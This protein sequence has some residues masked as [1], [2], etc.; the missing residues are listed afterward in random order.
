MK[1]YKNLYDQVCDFQN[2]LESYK[3]ARKCK[4]NSDYVIHFE[5]ELEKNLFEIKEKL[6]N[7]IY[8]FGQYKQFYVFDPKRRLIS[9]AP[10]GDRIVHH[11]L[12]RVIEPIFD[13]GFIFDSYACRKNKGTHKAILRLKNFMRRLSF[14]ISEEALENKKSFASGGWF[15]KGDIAKYFDSIDHDILFCLLKKKIGDKKVLDLLWNII[16]STSGNTGIPIGNLTS[17]LFS[18]IYLNELDKFIKHQLGAK[19]YIRY[20]DDFILLDSDKAKL[21]NW[22]EQISDF[23]ESHLLL[24]LHPK[25]REILPFRVGIDFLGYHVFTDHILIRQATVRRFWRRFKS[26]QMPKLSVDSYLGHFQF[27]DYFGLKR[28]IDKKY[29]ERYTNF[30]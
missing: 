11:A 24:R 7:Q 27:A 30:S 23:L 5:W 4:L 13:Q 21:K 26:G 25:K 22:R 28:K 6:E 1:T 9:A 2:I 14:E 10:F 18:N 17:Q 3:Q 20:V 12:C 16:C 8:Q 29:A 19:Y 15:L